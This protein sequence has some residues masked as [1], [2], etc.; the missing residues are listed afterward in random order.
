MNQGER[1]NLGDVTRQGTASGFLGVG[2]EPPKVTG[3]IHRVVRVV[4]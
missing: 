2:G 3:K 1:G 4:P